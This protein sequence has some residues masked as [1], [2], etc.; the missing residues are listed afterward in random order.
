[1]T[2][3][4]LGFGTLKRGSYCILNPDTRDEFALQQCLRTLVGHTQ[5]IRALA[6]IPASNR[7]PELLVSASDDLTM[8]VWEPN[9]GNCIGVLH[10]H[11]RGIWTIWY[12]PDLQILYSYSED[13]TIRLWELETFTCINTLTLSKPYRGMNITGVSGISIATKMTL[14]ALGAISSKVEE[15]Q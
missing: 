9:T 11:E 12:S 7:A 3:D 8:C 10:G 2:I 5:E 4:S 14:M 6:F 1:M 15:K 13:E